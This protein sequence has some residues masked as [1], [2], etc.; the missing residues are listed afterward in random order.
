MPQWAVRPGS[1]SKIPLRTVLSMR[2]PGMEATRR[3]RA[4]G[5]L[6]RRT[7]PKLLPTPPRCAPKRLE[8]AGRSR[9]GWLQ[10]EHRRRDHAR[11]E[12]SPHSAS[13]PTSGRRAVGPSGSRVCGPV[14]PVHVSQQ[15]LAGPR[16]RAGSTC[17]SVLRYP[18]PGRS[19]PDHRAPDVRA[20]DRWSPR[21][22][23]QGR[24][25]AAAWSSRSRMPAPRS[26]LPAGTGRAHRGGAPLVV[27]SQLPCT[28][29]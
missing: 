11:P 25:R 8:A 12:K 13:P 1:P 2:R 28:A 23:S 16:S 10:V 26:S 24:A 15:V 20:R 6:L 3:R 7:W 19:R 21:R 5:A 18:R 4:C 14:Q 22:R 27:G 9:R 29:W 17:A